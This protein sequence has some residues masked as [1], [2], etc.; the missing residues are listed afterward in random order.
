MGTVFRYVADAALKPLTGYRRTCQACGGT[1]VDVYSSHGRV[2]R[3]D[4]TEGDDCYAACAA[5]LRAGRVSHIGEWATDETIK[6]Y[7][8]RHLRDRPEIGRAHV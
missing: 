7:V 8:R 5:C 3:P 2:I 1:G 4:G 6:A